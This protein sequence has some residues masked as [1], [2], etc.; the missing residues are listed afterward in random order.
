MI[1]GYFRIYPNVIILIYFTLIL[2]SK[3]SFG[4]STGYAQ[5]GKN[6]AI[7]AAW[8]L[9]AKA[10]VFVNDDCSAALAAL[11]GIPTAPPVTLYLILTLLDKRRPR[12]ALLTL[13]SSTSSSCIDHTLALLIVL[14]TASTM[15]LPL[16]RSLSG[17]SKSLGSRPLTVWS[18]SIVTASRR[19]WAYE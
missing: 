13:I 7:Y 18:T 6:P 10:A 1:P 17:V 9:V 2:Y 5:W 11:A 15:I 12:L 3:G 4:N 19:L 16:L 14:T 8:R